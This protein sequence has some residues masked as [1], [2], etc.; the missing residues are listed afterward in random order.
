MAN[1]ALP[2]KAYSNARLAFEGAQ[3]ALVLSTHEDYVG[4]GALA[5]VY[6]ESNDASW[7]AKFERQKNA[8]PS[9]PT[10]DQWLD[11]R[12]DEMASIW[13]SVAAGQGKLLL[14][15]LLRVRQ[16]RKKRPDNWLH[17]NMIPRQ[18][19]AYEIFAENGGTSAFAETAEL[20]QGIY[21]VLCRETHARPRLDTFSVI[22]DQARDT[23]RLQVKARNPEQAR[24]AVTNGT[25]LSIS[26]TAA[27]L[28]WRRTGAA[29]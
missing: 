12:V 5:W 17:E 11:T 20:N 3:H 24:H 1:S 18:Q 7:R 25:E 19:R 13:D 15:A 27:A 26:E 22:H 23:I 16:Q 14:Q 10:A 6:F 9:N 29:R 2:H 4:A 8:H 28:R 21:Q